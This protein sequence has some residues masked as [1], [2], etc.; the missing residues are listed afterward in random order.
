MTSDA[1]RRCTVTA[2]VL[3]L[4]G[5]LTA[6]TGCAPQIEVVDLRD[7][8]QPTRE[9]MTRMPIVPLGGPSPPGV[10]SLGPVEAYGCGQSPS[11]AT[12]NAVQQL[13]I[14]ALQMHATA[15]VD[16]LFDQGGGNGSCQGNGTTANGIG[17]APRGIPPSY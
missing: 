3:A 14:K 17:V 8:P 7:V 1:G 10:G 2:V 11:V 5:I 13:Q 16:V 9:A 12:A 6:F 4:A 15:V